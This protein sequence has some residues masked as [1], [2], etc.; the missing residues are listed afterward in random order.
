MFLRRPSVVAVALACVLTFVAP[1][2]IAIA[3]LQTR[4]RSA[5]PNVDGVAFTTRIDDGHVAAAVERAARGARRRLQDGRCAGVV[6]AFGT[7]DGRPLRGVLAA[8][9]ATPAEAIS[10]VIFRDGGTSGAC[11]GSVAAFTGPGSRIVFVCGG[12]FAGID[13]GRAELV[14][15]HELLHTLG[16]GE[17]PPRSSAIDR[18]VAT[19]CG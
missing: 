9:N 3:V 10:R 18:A 19:S 1:Q 5:A 13:R 7:R 2:F 11:G 12:R 4:P 6:D 15:I 8:L 14:I 16:L 17:R